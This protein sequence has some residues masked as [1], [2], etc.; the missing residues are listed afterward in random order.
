MT[1]RIYLAGPMS[2]YPQFNYP[3]FDEA[4]RR[5]CQ[6]GHDVVSPAE[7]DDPEIR[8]MA[9]ASAAG[10]PGDSGQSWGEFLARDVRIIADDC[11]AL[12]LLPG[13]AT[14]RG[15]RLEAYV[16]MLCG[17]T[18]YYYDGRHD[19]ANLIPVTHSEVRGQL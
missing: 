4:K 14:S 11:N 3:A 2:N 7:L 9:L 1:K 16:A 15:A 10:A 8:A 5:L 13:W 6:R 12:A 18:I 17:H 19:F